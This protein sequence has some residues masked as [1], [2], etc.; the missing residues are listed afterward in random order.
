MT[1][2]L[3]LD[4]GGSATRARLL[5]DGS[6]AAEASADGAN[7]AASGEELAEAS[8]RS[9]LD[10]LRGGHPGEIDAVCAG[11]AGSGAAPARAWL[12]RRLADLTGASRV[13]VVDDVELVLPAAGYAIGVAVVCGTGSIVHGRGP[14]ASARAG[15]WGWLLGDEGSGYSLVRGGLRTLLARRDAGKPAGALGEAL[16]AAAGQDTLDALLGAFYAD[17]RPGR[18]A[19]HA[20]VVLGCGDP[21]VTELVGAE[22]RLIAAR[23]APLARRLGLERAPVVLAG[24]LVRE[25]SVQVALQAALASV[26]PGWPVELLHEEPVVGA[27]ALALEQLGPPLH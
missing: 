15:G 12:T 1:S 5:V 24:G 6:V 25:S 27:V 23:A 13:S 3:G 16:L 2:V 11:A 4:I 7:P 21:G 26:L 10:A 22:A 8:L 9:L 20:P 17:P 14:T 19:A 18:W